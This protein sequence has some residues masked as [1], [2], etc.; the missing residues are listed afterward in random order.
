MCCCGMK[1]FCV[2]S[3][4]S[5]L[6]SIE[7]PEISVRSSKTIN[8]YRLTINSGWHAQDYP[9]CHESLMAASLAGIMCSMEYLLIIVLDRLLFVVSFRN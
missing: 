2:S 4:L 5:T 6:K 1:C 9:T 3:G 7:S 8:L